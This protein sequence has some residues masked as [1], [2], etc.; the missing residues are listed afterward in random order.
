M[1]IQKT[2]LAEIKLAFQGVKLEDGIGIWQ[3]QGIDDY[4]DELTIAVLKSK[5]EREDWTKITEADLRRCYSSLSFFDAKGMRFCL[6]R[7]MV[8]DILDYDKGEAPD[9]VFTLTYELEGEYSQNRFELFNKP[10][11]QC[12]IHFLE[13]KLSCIVES[14]K[15]TAK[16][17][18]EYQEISKALIFWKQR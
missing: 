15:E 10:Q 6:P 2:L 16:D 11:I 17:N 7:Y 3:A 12:I 8:Y 9:V 5:D 1:I 13:W 18:F 14:Y 4:A